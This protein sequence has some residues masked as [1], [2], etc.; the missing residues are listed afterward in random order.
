MP[1]T[2]RMIL[3]ILLAGVAA[4]RPIRADVDAGEPF[5]TLPL[6][7]EVNCADPADPH[8]FVQ[9]EPGASHLDT[10]LDRRCRVL[11]PGPKPKYFAYRLGAGRGLS[12]RTA[13]VLAAEYPQD[14]PRTTIVVNRG[15]DVA[16]GWHTGSTL[17]DGLFGWAGTNPESLVRAP[18]TR[19]WEWWTEL[20]FLHDRFADVKL[21][22]DHFV[23]PFGPADGFWAIVFAPA[24]SDDPKSAG[25]AV[26][27]LRLYAVPDPDAL[28]LPVRYPPAPLPRRHLFDREEM[29]VPV[30]EGMRE[31]QPGLTNMDL[32]FDFKAQGLRFLGVNT[33]AADLLMFGHNQGWDAGD[34]EWY[35]PAPDPMRFEKTLQSVERAGLEVLPY[36]EYA[37]SM[38]LNRQVKVRTLGRA[39]G[40]PYTH[41]EWSELYHGDVTDPRT[42]LDAERLLDATVLRYAD[43]AP[44]A[45]V[46]FRTRVS[47]LPVSFTDDVLKRFADAA[48][49]AGVTRARLRT[50]GGL[51]GRFLDWWLDQR[52]AFFAALHDHLK[53]KG[54][55]RPVLFT[56]WSEE[57]GPSLTGPTTIVTDYPPA[58]PN[59]PAGP[60]GRRPRVGS[61][62]SVVAE[63]RY[64]ASA[65]DWTPTWADWEWQYALPRADPE[66]WRTAPGLLLTYPFSRRYTVSRREDFDAFRGPDGLAAVRMT[67]LNEN[68]DG[69][70]LGYFLADVER[71]G[72]G[73]LLPEALAVANGDPFWMGSLNGIAW[74]RGF[75]QWVRRFNAAFLALPALPSTVAAGASDEKDVVV[76]VIAAG[77]QGTWVA[78]VNAS[79]EPAKGVTIRL[80]DGSK[81]EDAVTGGS[82]ES[83]AFTLSPTGRAIKLSFAPCELRSLHLAAP[84]GDSSN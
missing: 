67:P 64:L 62:A 65:T 18:L 75:P 84:G 41:I 45:G 6:V 80:P 60:D 37:G 53:T 48:G 70:L 56:P 81:L 9:S 66:R 33:F 76:R 30:V 36:F 4:P 61:L 11:E 13:Y 52:L 73:C 34:D 58:W 31:P 5:G 22:R 78:A 21:T 25:A 14:E 72:P 40:A 50:D 27:R 7:D 32:M 23:R 39:E 43:R 68:R 74:E 24:A 20:F 1:P 54:L 2:G 16:L 47:H 71:A 44:F 46:W 82:L 49:A 12:P 19:A 77:A 83:E 51:R 63:G 57:C 8:P 79:L 15:N 38:A 10:V 28:A 29:A 3:L 59:P 35:V 26:R 69:G 42:L 55:A 17:G